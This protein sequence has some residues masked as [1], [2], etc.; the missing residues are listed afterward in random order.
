MDTTRTCLPSAASASAPVHVVSEQFSDARRS[1]GVPKPSKDVA[2]LP[3]LGDAGLPTPVSSL[4]G[5]AATDKGNDANRVSHDHDENLHSA[6]VSEPDESISAEREPASQ[7]PPAA[8]PVSQKRD[9]PESVVSKSPVVQEASMDIDKSPSLERPS[10]KLE[11]PRTSPESLPNHNDGDSSRSC[12]ELEKDA[13]G[14]QSM[15]PVATSGQTSRSAESIWVCFVI[16][17]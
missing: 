17:L 5:Q 9:L 1:D 8:V 13:P 6:N 7:S 4:Q 14:S 2:T 16:S 10:S 3:E 12:A 11:R 15:K